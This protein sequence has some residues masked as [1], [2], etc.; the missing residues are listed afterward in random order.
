MLR[1]VL[2]FS[3]F[4]VVGVLGARYLDLAGRAP[5]TAPAARAAV[6]PEPAPSNSRTMVIR[7]GEGGHFEVD[8]RVDGRRL[9]FMVDTGASSIA[10]REGDAGRLDLHPAKR[11]YN[12]KISTA[13]GVALAAR[14]ELRMVEVGDIIVRNLDALVIPDEALGVNL[15]GM[16]FLSRVRWTHERGKL[17]LE[18]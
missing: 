3:L 5:A 14:V 8:A 7:A 12:V 13:N 2:S 18:Q 10:L 11:D 15:L 16:S 9:K 17:V 6:A 4:L 1:I